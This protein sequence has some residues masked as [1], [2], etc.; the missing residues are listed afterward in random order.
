MIYIFKTKITLKWKQS[1]FEEILYSKFAIKEIAKWPDYD[2]FQEK[3]D[4]LLSA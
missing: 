3:D 1:P 4:P 2:W